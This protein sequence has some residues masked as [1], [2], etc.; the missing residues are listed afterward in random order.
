MDDP[1]DNF[2]SSKKDWSM[3]DFDIDLSLVIIF[4]A[5]LKTPEDGEILIDFS[6]NRINEEVFALL[7]DLVSRA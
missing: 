6:K 3:Q 7:V 2:K 5:V 4:S 1:Y